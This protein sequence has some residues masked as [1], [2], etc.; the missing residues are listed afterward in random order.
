MSVK[1]V[2][3]ATGQM[4]SAP[5][6]TGALGGI[7]VVVA[8]VGIV[9]VT[10]DSLDVLAL[11]LDVGGT[12]VVLGALDSDKGGSVTR[13][14]ELVEVVDALVEG[15]VIYGEVEG[16]SDVVTVGAVE[17]TTERELLA[18]ADAE[19]LGRAVDVSCEAL[20]LA[21][22]LRDDDVARDASRSAFSAACAFANAVRR[23]SCC[24][25]ARLLSRKSASAWRRRSR[26][27]SIAARCWR[28]SAN[29]STRSCVSARSRAATGAMRPRARASFATS[30]MPSG[31]YDGE[32]PT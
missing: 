17:F 26:A 12:L 11:V 21:L 13:V 16:D 8:A 7:D 15:L 30:L 5:T 3:P 10:D 31:V 6:V 14:V 29:A 9:E 4:N 27:R 1:T 23:A 32:R 18:D 20:L 28:N 2:G 22:L 25:N 19:L 24:S